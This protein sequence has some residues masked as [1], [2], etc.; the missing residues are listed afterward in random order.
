MGVVR[1]VQL[2]DIE[3]VDYEE[4]QPNL[5][6]FQRFSETLHGE[7]ERLGRRLGNTTGR[8]DFNANS[9]EQTAAYLLGALGLEELKMTPSGGRLMCELAAIFVVVFLLVYG[10]CCFF[11]D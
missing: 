6:Y 11:L 8:E 4:A 2:W 7:V 3:Q 9:G 10:T 1:Y 5:A